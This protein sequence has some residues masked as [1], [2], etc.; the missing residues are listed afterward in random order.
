MPFTQPRWIALIA[1]LLL[2]SVGVWA[3]IEWPSLDGVEH[4][5][6]DR[7]LRSIDMAN[8]REFR[9]NRN[10]NWWEKT[11]SG[12]GAVGGPLYRPYQ[13]PR[14]EM[15][16][17]FKRDDDLPHKA[18]IEC[19]FMK[20]PDSGDPPRVAF[21]SVEIEWEHFLDPQAR[22]WVSWKPK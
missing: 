16:V 9:I 18:W 3:N 11:Y 14:V 10:Y 1:Y 15:I 8:I 20:V 2:S 17:E 4:E 5:C 12:S 13:D 7:L 22:S 19:I 6:R 21:E